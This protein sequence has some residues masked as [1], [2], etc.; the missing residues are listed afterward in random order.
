MVLLELDFKEIFV[1][2]FWVFLFTICKGCLSIFILFVQLSSLVVHDLWPAVMSDCYRT[3]VPV[4]WSR[5]WHVWIDGTMS[6]VCPELCYLII[7][8]FGICFKDLIKYL[9]ECCLDF[10]NLC[11]C[12]VLLILILLVI[13]MRQIVKISLNCKIC[14]MIIM[15][16]SDCLK[17][18]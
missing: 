15:N 9:V 4:I 17:S 2:T 1:F 18:H 11:S 5:K 14:C 16:W 8:I 3:L 10:V 13:P 6:L 7:R 12:D